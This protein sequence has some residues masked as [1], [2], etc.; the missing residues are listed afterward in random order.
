VKNESN[1]V[2]RSGRDLP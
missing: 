2:L 1:S